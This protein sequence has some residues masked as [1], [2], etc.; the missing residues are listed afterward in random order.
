MITAADVIAVARPEVGVRE[1]RSESGHPNNIVKYAPQVPGLG[2]AQ[3]MAWCAVFVSWCAMVAGAAD[4]F[5]RT[6]SCATGLRWFRERGRVSEYPAV[7]AQVFFGAPGSPYGPGGTHTGLVYAYD[8]TYIYTI[9]GNTNATGSPE[10]DGVYLKKRL[11]RDPYVH[12][13]GYPAYAGGIVSADPAWARQAPPKP[14]PVPVPTPAP[15][16]PAFPGAGAFRLNAAHSAVTLL[17]QR[18]IAKGYV[19]HHNGDGYQA[20]PVFTIFTLRNVRDFQRAQGWSG[21][22]A[23]GYPG[24]ET[25]RRLWL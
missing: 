19:R 24:P 14:A 7:G 1:G 4:L 2:W 9:E 15:A 13:Y 6:A 5:P 3:G 10:G 23:D 20:G 21:T 22:D 11:R 12:A 8:A 18:L 16:P 25:W 17:D